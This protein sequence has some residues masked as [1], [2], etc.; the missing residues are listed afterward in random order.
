[1]IWGVIISLF[2]AKLEVGLSGLLKMSQYNG[3]F[4]ELTGLSISRLLMMH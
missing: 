2:I 1:M 4:I 3:N